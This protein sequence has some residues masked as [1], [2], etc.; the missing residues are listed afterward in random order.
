MMH[1]RQWLVVSFLVSTIV[2]CGGQNSRPTDEQKK[3]KEAARLNVQLASGYIRRGNLEV[4]KAK[5]LKAIE[6][7]EYYVPAYT[8]MAVLMNMLGDYEEA[9]KYYR[10]ALD[11]NNNDPDLHNN[12][13]T[14]L[15][16]HGKFEEAMK[17]FN[18]ALKNQFYETPE[19]AHSNMGY[20][21]MRGDK[22]DYVTA[23]KHLRKALSKNPNISS[24]LLAMGELG[25][26][27]G[28]FLMSRAYMQRYHALIKADAHSLWVQIQA[29]YALGD[30]DYFVKLSRQLL[31]AFP[32]SE[33]AKK[34]MR[35][36]NKW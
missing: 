7:D 29:E 35:L 36:P 3:D 26:E 18:I 21:M 23:E 19:A 34:V 20:C 33:E 9:E 13:G 25:L 32:E 5:L 6:H 8:T 27:T 30:R 28:K 10:E 31:K 16:N 2:A 11:L 24:A 22:P 4:A 1:I 14:F 12:Y 15:C 17:Q